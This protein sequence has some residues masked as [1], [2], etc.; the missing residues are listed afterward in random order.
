MS[1]NGLF[2]TSLV[3]AIPGVILACLMVMAFV[4]YAGGPTWWVKILAG[5]LLLIGM[6]LTAMP[7]G[8]M[9]FAGPK[10][11]KA[12]K[13]EKNEAAEKEAAEAESEA[14]GES[15]RSGATDSSLEVTGADESAM[16]GEFVAGD[17]DASGEDFD[18]GPGSEFEM[19]AAE[20]D[21]EAE[22]EGPKKGR[23]KAPYSRVATPFSLYASLSTQ[24]DRC[25]VGSGRTA[26]GLG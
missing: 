26:A 11:E 12:P 18:L 7:V 16:T 1:K 6:L 14:A 24:A 9:L 23:S 17:D 13:T 25:A 21:V 5:M 3:A 4:N 20:A 15:A 2:L 8:I 19:E 22:D 10:A